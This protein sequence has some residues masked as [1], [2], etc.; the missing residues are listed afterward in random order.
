SK[1]A[2]SGALRGGRGNSGVIF[3]QFFRGF[4]KALEGMGNVGTREIAQA[5]VMASKTAYKAVMRPQ[6]GTILTVGRHMAEVSVKVANATDDI[7]IFA[8]EVINE[9]YAILKR[10][11]D[12]LPVLKQ[13]GVVDSGG[14]GLMVFLVGAMEGVGIDNPRIAEDSAGDEETN[15]AALASINPE[16]ITFGYCTEFFIVVDGFSEDNEDKLKAYLESMGDSVAVVADDDMVKVHVHTENPG[17]VLE[18]CMGYGL[19]DGIKIDNMR[20]QHQDVAGGAAAAQ[21]RKELGV[22]AISSGDGFKEI[23][24][25]LGADLVIEGGQTMN[26]SAEDIAK[27]VQQVNADSV[28]ILPNNKNIILA[29]EQAMYLCEGQTVKVIASKTMPQ[30]IAALMNYLPEGDADEVFE[31]MQ[32][33]LGDVSTGQITLAI[34]DTEMDG[35]TVSEGDYIGILEGKIVCT[36]G[37]LDATAKELIDIMLEPDFDMFTIYPGAEADEGKTSALQ[38]YVEGQHDGCELT[39]AFGGQAV[40]EYIFSAE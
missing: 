35:H 34:R 13:A 5:M 4:S 23:F 37:D 29:A 19:L 2:A 12:M 17:A 1:A 6:E 27:G 20:L 30:G 38:D 9:G 26:P 18:K 21:E 25:E 22:V 31:D 3:S 14:E 7:Q 15:F 40:Y 32:G 36:N 8:R 24:M 16:D 28:I 33:A 39:V 10:T 11:P